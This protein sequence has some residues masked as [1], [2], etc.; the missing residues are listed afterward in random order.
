MKCFMERG[1]LARM[2][3]GH[4]VYFWPKVI[5]LGDRQYSQTHSVVLLSWFGAT[6]IPFG[7]VEED[8]VCDVSSPSFSSY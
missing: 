4:L 1:G 2:A 7:V 8:G 5:S 3:C 6:I